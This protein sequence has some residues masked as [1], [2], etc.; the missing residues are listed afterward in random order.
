MSDPMNHLVLLLDFVFDVL[1]NFDG[2]AISI[3]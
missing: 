1:R 2:C 3:S